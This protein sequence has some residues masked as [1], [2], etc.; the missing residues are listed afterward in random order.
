MGQ[1]SHFKTILIMLAL[2]SCILL[3]TTG[4]AVDIIKKET[5]SPSPDVTVDI[6]YPNGM[7]G[8]FSLVI[9]AHNGGATK[10]DWGDYPSELA[11]KGYITASIGWK[12]FDGHADFIDAC[13]SIVKIYSDKVDTSCIAF[14][15]GCHGA[16]K[17]IEAM[18]DPRNAISFKAIV[19][20]S[21][22]EPVVLK[23]KHAP[24]LGI[25]STEDR[26]GGHYRDFTKKYVEEMISVP[27][28]TI[29]YK[30]TSHGNEL[31][32]D[33]ASKDSIR[34]AI[35]NWLSANLK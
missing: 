21:V 11:K 26:L 24:I 32:T 1:R 2:A 27:K 8:I 5:L 23:G 6:C 13:N 34:K 9:F 16:V 7:T 17:M 20:L 10:E 14:I 12:N 29:A 31:V 35:G 25:Y 30:G 4:N 15:G 33:N 28:K 3:G 22:S 19:F 18:N